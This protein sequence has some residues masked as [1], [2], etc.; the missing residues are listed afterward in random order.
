M[1]IYGND[2]PTKDGTCIRDYVHVSDLVH[3]HLL[4]INENYEKYRFRVFNLGSSEGFSVIDII[5]SVERIIGKKNINMKIG[6]KEILR[7]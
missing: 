3:A 6:V 1:K 5:N 4:A 7:Y 2:Y